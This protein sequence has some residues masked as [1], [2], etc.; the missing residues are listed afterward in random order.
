MVCYV[1]EK[2]FSPLL[3]LAFQCVVE[4]VVRN[5]GEGR[6]RSKDESGLRPGVVS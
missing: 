4:E 6:G 1:Q 2:V 3:F 5:R